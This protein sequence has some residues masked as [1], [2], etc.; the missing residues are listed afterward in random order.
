MSKVK[1]IILEY[2][3]IIL[4]G[5][6][7]ALS[8]ALFVTPNHFA[9]AGINGIAVMVQ[10]KLNFSIGYMSLIVNLPLCL[11]AYL[12]VDKKFAIKTLVFCLTYSIGYLFLSTLNIESFVYNAN[13]VDTVYPVIIAG[14]ISGFCYGVLLRI[15]CCTGGTDIVGRYISKV[16]PQINYFWITFIL[17]AIVAVSSYF[18]YAT[19]SNGVITYDYKPVCLCLLYCFFSSFIG[20]RIIAGARKACK[21]FIVTDN[22][23]E[24]EKEIIEQFHHTATRLTGYGSYSNTE[25]QILICAINKQQMVDFQNML[26]KYSNTFAFVEFIDHTIGNFKNIKR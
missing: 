12:L 4:M 19:E 16:K 8:Y 24:I 7:L 3:I 2:L 26:K 15:N 21:F 6:L 18:V 1:N 5:G 17:N 22:P 25:K 14:L 13:N 23:D 10:Y 11:F 9:P 20:D